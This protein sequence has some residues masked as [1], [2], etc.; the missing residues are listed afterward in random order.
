MPLNKKLIK[1]YKTRYHRLTIPVTAKQ[2]IVFPS[3]SLF[4]LCF[5]DITV[6]ET[7]TVNTKQ[8]TTAIEFT[9]YL[10]H[11]ECIGLCA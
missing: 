7:Y 2:H 4:W 10:S 8:S 3:Y 6:N 9:V 1:S 11:M 5:I